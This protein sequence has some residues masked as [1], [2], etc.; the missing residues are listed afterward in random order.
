MDWM[1][2]DQVARHTLLPPGYRFARF[3]RADIPAV[4]AAL[5]CWFPGI[6]V[7]A[8][9]AYLREDFYD[10]RVYF[11]AEPE[12]VGRDISVLMIRYHDEL[13]G[14]FSAQ[15]DRDTLSLYGRMG[16]VAPEHRR[17]NL[18]EAVIGVTELLGRHMGMGMAFGMATLHIPFMQR[19]LEKHGFSLVGITP[20]Y[21]REMVQPGVVKRVFEALYAK[22]LVD[23]EDLLMPDPENLTPRTRALFETLFRTQP[24]ANG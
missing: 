10:K 16:A 14:V 15:R 9:S 21:D 22:V 7:G 2:S 18:A 4:I 13:V 3:E 23:Q 19:A 20:G 5:Q 11:E 6:A 12:T 8:G 17:Q 24:C 1:T